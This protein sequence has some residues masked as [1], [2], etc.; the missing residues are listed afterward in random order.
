M[1]NNTG[2]LLI[3]EGEDPSQKM[4]ELNKTACNAL[5]DCMNFY[6]LNKLYLQPELE[7][8]IDKIMQEYKQAFWTYISNKNEMKGYPSKDLEPFPDIKEDERDR[9]MQ[10]LRENEQI[11][12]NIEQ[13]LPL[14][15]EQL[16]RDFRKIIGIKR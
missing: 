2:C 13:E 15:I 8:K 3:Y 12:K 11:S 5:V 14:M 16:K 6:A 10:H 4:Q 7:E 9:Y 1:I